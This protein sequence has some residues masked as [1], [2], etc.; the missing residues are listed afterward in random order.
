[1]V[2]RSRPGQESFTPVANS[3]LYRVYGSAIPLPRSV[4]V[5]LSPGTDGSTGVVARVV[6]L[7]ILTLLLH[8]L[9]I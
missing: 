7:H 2:K 3:V 8:K 4:C 5:G 9:R 6:I 1:M